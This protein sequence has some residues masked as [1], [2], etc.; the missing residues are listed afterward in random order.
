MPRL[1][2]YGNVVVRSSGKTF[3]AFVTTCSIRVVN[4]L[5]AQFCTPIP[6]IRTK[7]FLKETNE[8]SYTS[9]NNISSS[10]LTWSV[11]PE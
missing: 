3:V 1:P 6:Y 8:K 2:V 11:A 10:F 9:L 4:N 5:I 7:T